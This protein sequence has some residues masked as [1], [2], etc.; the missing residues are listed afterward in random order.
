MEQWWYEDK[1]EPTANFTLAQT[2]K[3]TK[4]GFITESRARQELRELNYDD[5]HINVYI[6][7]IQ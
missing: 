1:T 4:A 7:S 5:E 3:F 2:L 6:R